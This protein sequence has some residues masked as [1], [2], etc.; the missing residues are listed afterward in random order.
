MDEYKTQ[1]YEQIPYQVAELNKQIILLKA[2]NE[3]LKE[4]IKASC[5]YYAPGGECALT[6]HNCCGTSKCI[7]RLH[8]CFD[9]IENCINC[10]T[11]TM[12]GCGNCKKGYECDGTLS[13][14]IL[15]KIK[16]VN[17]NR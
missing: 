2:E 12:Y 6:A 10:C 4:N 15:Q 8:Q 9:E 17:G 14:L 5:R 3:E 11:T 16:E 1:N 7:E 13:D